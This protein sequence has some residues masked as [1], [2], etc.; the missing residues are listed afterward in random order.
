MAAPANSSSGTSR[1]VVTGLGLLVALLLAVFAAPAPLWLGLVVL[2]LAAAAWEW[3]RLLKFGPVFGHLF[4]GFTAILGTALAMSQVQFL[5]QAYLASLGFWLL[6]VPL[7]LARAWPLPGRILGWLLG[8]L[9]LLPAG[10]ALLYL[11]EQG[12]GLLL[13]AI[14][15]SAVADS[16]AYFAGRA[17]GRHK[18]AP[19]ISPGKTWEG[20]IGA[21]ITVS[22][23]ALLV[24]WYYACDSQCLLSLIAASGLLFALSIEGDLFESWC[25]RV[26]GVKDSGNLL[27]GHGGLLDR[28]DS[29][30][31]VLPIAALLWLWL[32]G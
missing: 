10:L 17:F 28:V 8:W 12:A 19:R 23:F 26:A 15:I 31:A 13:G 6:L 14:A 27:P 3:A 24:G 29:H 18:L 11:R 32:H 20:A 7:W 2:F 1:R 5:P 9:L 30:L 16:A 22:L 25:K 4:V 21:G